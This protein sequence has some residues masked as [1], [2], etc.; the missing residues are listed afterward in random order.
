MDL[1]I[2]SGVVLLLAVLVGWQRH[3]AADRRKWEREAEARDYARWL[4][5]AKEPK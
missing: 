3:V 2:L 4:E 1:W 5:K